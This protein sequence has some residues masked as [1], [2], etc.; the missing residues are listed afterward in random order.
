MKVFAMHIKIYFYMHLYI[1]GVEIGQRKKKS[2]W[3]NS[4]VYIW[5]YACVCCESS[6]TIYWWRHSKSIRLVWIWTLFSFVINFCTH[7]SS[8]FSLL[9]IIII[10]FSRLCMIIHFFSF[11]SSLD[12]IEDAIIKSINVSN[13]VINGWSF[14]WHKPMNINM[15]RKNTRKYTH[16][17]YNEQIRDIKIV[18][19][20]YYIKYTYSIQT[21]DVLIETLI[22]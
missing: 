14:I 9:N 12:I 4:L 6:F 21:K 2:K 7:L 3:I 5:T 15:Q 22:D 18:R 1:W 16:A 20:C 17:W 13:K 19:H 10:Y 11:Y 8:F